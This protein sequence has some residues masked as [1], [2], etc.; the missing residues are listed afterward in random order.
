VKRVEDG[1]EI[2]VDL[3]HLGAVLVGTEA[4]PRW[5]VFDCPCRTGHRI[6]LNLDR[7]RRPFWSVSNSRRLSIEPSVDS[8][9]PE[10]K[11]HYWVRR[12][13]IIWV[14]AKGVHNV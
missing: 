4:D 12:G 2:P 10:L 8:R 5:L 1:D 6:M 9:R 11:C 13:K 14:P 3:P 7:D